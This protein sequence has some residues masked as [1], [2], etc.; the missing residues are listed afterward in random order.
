ML[1]TDRPAADADALRDRLHGEV[2]GPDDAGYDGA[3]RAWN[4]AVEQ[5]PA[6][7]AVPSSDADVIATVG[8]A[9]EQGL[10]IAT[11]ATGHGARRRDLSDAILVNTRQMRG[12]R[13][14]PGA[15]RA[16][17]RAGAVWADVTGPAS[18]YGLAPLA[19]T[20]PDVGVVGYTLGGGLGWL[21][22]RYG[23][24][25]H[26][27]TAIEIVLPDGRHARADAH[28][29]ADL[30]WA[31][32]GGGGGLGIVTALEFEL[33]PVGQLHGGALMWPV[34]RAEEIFVAWRDW[35][36]TVPDEVSSL[37]RI[38]NVGPHSF[39][40]VEAAIMGDPAILDPLRAL[41]PELGQI[42]PM[43]PS[44]LTSIHND[45]EEPT[46]GMGGHRML[47]SLPDGAIA[48][49]VARAT[50]P[51]VCVELRHLGGALKRP[52]N[53]VLDAL[54]GS[55]ALYAI[56]RTPDA[57]S[58]IAVDAALTGLTEVLEPWDAGR[59]ILNFS[60]RPRRFYHDAACE[61]L[62]AV[63]IRHD[64]DGMFRQP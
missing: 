10:R 33:H 61:R 28:T 14:D 21:G 51:L 54:H 38:L 32:R 55:Y 64:A 26:S 27:V 40:I 41:D 43:R 20:A 9:R 56:G 50:A 16:R 6:L 29:E 31:L 11:Q 22:R 3:R 4:L 36:E 46:A 39:V 42:G 8:Y 58:A 25:C 24:A 12:V 23:L 63:K 30:F 59:A 5:R 18:A 47:R 48:E 62:Q 34:E 35:T 53:A 52:R 2:H 7:V 17:V 37:C 15:R 19:G 13:I 45:P 57:E 60:D 44:E 1:I 49:L